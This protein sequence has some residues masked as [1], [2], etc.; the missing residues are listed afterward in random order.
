MST[1]LSPVTIKENKN[2]EPW[3][4]RDHAALRTW[5]VYNSHAEVYIW[6]TTNHF[7]IFLAL[8]D[9]ETLGI[10]ETLGEATKAATHFVKELTKGHLPS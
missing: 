1:H 6:E 2:E 10:Y 7:K 4:I 8:N 3:T 9:T 5:K